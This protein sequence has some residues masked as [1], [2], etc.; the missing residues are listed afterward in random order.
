MKI[1]VKKKIRNRY[2]EIY[3]NGDGN[4]AITPLNKEAARVIKKI[5]GAKKQLGCIYCG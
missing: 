5:L 1:I 3:I 2:L 4:L